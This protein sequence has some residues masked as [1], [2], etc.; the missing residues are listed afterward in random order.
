VVEI[1]L[2][3]TDEEV[4]EALAVADAVW[5]APPV[6]LPIARALSFAGWYVGIARQGGTP[7]GMCAGFIGVHGG[8][9]H[10]HSHLAAVLPPAQGAGVGRALKRHQRAWCLDHGIETVT[11]TVD[12]LVRANARFNLHHLGAVGD[13][14]LVDLY[15]PMDDDINR[16]QPSDRLLMRWDLRSDRTV[17]AL[18]S[19][20]SAIE[21]AVIRGDGAA[22]AVTTIDGRPRAATTDADV[23]LVATPPG[24][25]ALR[26]TDPDLA[27]AW[28]L[29]VRDALGA[30]FADGLRPTSLTDDGSYLCCREAP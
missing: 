13:R 20:L 12:P 23:R 7:V 28:R 24:I 15:G 1:E 29:A 22:D 2:A 6:S 18:D 3:T 19:P 30:A 5:G 21:A 16:G 9:L 26:R 4:D 10:L 11:W 8:D 27:L 14:Y 25:V 17:L